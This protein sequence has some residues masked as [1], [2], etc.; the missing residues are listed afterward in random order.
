[1]VHVD[2]SLNSRFVDQKDVITFFSLAERSTSFNT[3]NVLAIN[4][5]DLSNSKETQKKDFELRVSYV[6]YQLLLE[7]IDLIC[8]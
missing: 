2:Q 7:K 4:W 6:Q 5:I 1:M 8:L 3:S